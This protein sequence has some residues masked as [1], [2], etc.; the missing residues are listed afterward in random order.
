[1]ANPHS[2]IKH[3][4]ARA[5]AVSSALPQYAGSIAAC[6]NVHRSQA[7]GLEAATSRRENAR[8]LANLVDLRSC[9]RLM[10]F[11]DFNDLEDDILNI[12]IDLKEDH[13]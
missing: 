10:L 5:C 9:A 2:R 1:M 12:A 13:R 4:L 7:T 8:R 6:N 3:V 11:Y